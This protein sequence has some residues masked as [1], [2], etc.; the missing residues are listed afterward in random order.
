[1]PNDELNIPSYKEVLQLIAQK[2]YG[3]LTKRAELPEEYPKELT[4]ETRKKVEEVMLSA[5]SG[6]ILKAKAVPSL[7]AGLLKKQKLPGLGFK[8]E[9]A[10]WSIIR[11][12]QK[13]NL[14][15][16]M[17]E[18]MSTPQKELSRIKGIKWTGGPASTERGKYVSTLEEAQGT[19][20]IEYNPFQAN[21][22]TVVHEFV[23][24]RHYK[25]EAE[26][27]VIA[28][29]LREANQRVWTKIMDNFRTQRSTRSGPTYE[30]AW[31]DFYWNVSQTEAMARDLSKVPMG[32]FGKIYP[33]Q[34]PKY[35]ERAEVW[36]DTIVG[37]G[38]TRKMW[39][40]IIERGR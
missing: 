26:E 11:P 7:L 17:K 37:E 28:L 35:S 4:E 21:L 31:N 9:L 24:A 33:E 2:A 39:E 40:E 36:L 6:G 29:G 13:K 14:A 12:E 18:V 5:Q 20:R 25:P 22:R 34:L 23:H 3:G 15:A 1:M 27:S 16:M 8:G 10:Y 32:K 19:P 38:A 30:Q